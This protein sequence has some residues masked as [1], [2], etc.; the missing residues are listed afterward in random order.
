MKKKKNEKVKKHMLRFVQDVRAVRGTERY[1]SDH[2]IVLCKVRLV[3][4]WIKRTKVVDRVRKTVLD[5]L[6]GRE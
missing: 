6:R 1:I 4:T 2:P 5:L 3:G